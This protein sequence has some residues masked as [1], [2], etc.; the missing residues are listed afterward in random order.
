MLLFYLIAISV[1]GK[2]DSVGSQYV[3]S[4]GI[5]GRALDAHI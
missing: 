5:N 1:T 2:F 3:R 4:P